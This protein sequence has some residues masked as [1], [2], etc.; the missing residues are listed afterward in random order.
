MEKS[1][2]RIHSAAGEV[3]SVAVLGRRFPLVAVNMAFSLLWEVR[4]TLD[5]KDIA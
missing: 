1:S 2:I 4:R 3:V 5:R